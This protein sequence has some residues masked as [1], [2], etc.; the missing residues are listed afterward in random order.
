MHAGAVARIAV[1]NGF[2]R[3]RPA[4]GG[5][6]TWTEDPAMGDP[7][8]SHATNFALRVSSARARRASPGIFGPLGGGLGLAVTL[9]HHCGPSG[10]SSLP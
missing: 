6:H 8:L 3:P 10:G 5:R 1:R 9:L 7:G 4:A 2:F